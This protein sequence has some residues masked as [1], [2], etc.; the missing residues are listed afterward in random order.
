MRLRRM[1][2]GK[3]S[4]ILVGNLLENIQLEDKKTITLQSLLERHDGGTQSGWNWLMIMSNTHLRTGS[5]KVLNFSTMQF[6]SFIRQY[7]MSAYVK[8]A[9]QLPLLST[10]TPCL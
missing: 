3:E 10:L 6:L 5:V 7:N 2:K 9:V 8:M 1:E 4:R